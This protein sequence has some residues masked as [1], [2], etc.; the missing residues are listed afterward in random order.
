VRQAANAKVAIIL[1]SI[2]AS[3]D[4]MESEGWQMEMGQC[5]ITYIKRKIQNIPFS[6]AF[7]Y[8]RVKAN[9]AVRDYL[10]AGSALEKRS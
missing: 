4:T 8:H 5:G 3:S 10:L 1:G 6:F 2:P 9:L 7:S